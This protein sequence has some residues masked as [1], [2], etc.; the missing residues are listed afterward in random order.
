VPPHR[1]I[2]LTVDLFAQCQ[3]S[4]ASTNDL[5]VYLDPPFSKTPTAV[6]MTNTVVRQFG[7]TID[8]IV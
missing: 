5:V 6:N 4:D 2:A 8:K 7:C 1:Q 3:L